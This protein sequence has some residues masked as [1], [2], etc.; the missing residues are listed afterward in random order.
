MSFT[1]KRKPFICNKKL[2]HPLC[3]FCIVAPLVDRFPWPN[4]KVGRYSSECLYWNSIY[5]A[6]APVLQE[7]TN[8]SQC[9]RLSDGFPS[10]VL[11]A[12]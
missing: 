10:R 7:T 2:I 11:P 1:S 4:H 9:A 12:V 8:R 6:L 3:I 5:H